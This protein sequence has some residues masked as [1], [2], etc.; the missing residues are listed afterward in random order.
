M[1]QRASYEASRFSLIILSG[2][3]E[4]CPSNRE[5]ARGGKLVLAISL[6]DSASDQAVRVHR[7]ARP[8]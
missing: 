6:P 8:A 7:K 2:Q 4:G 3:V 5:L 1:G